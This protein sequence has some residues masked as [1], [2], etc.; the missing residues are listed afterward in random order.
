MFDDE[1]LDNLTDVIDGVLGSIVEDLRAL[2]RKNLV[3]PHGRR[4]FG[5]SGS[6]AINFT[7]TQHTEH[8]GDPYITYGST[9][10]RSPDCDTAF[11]FVLGAADG[12]R[13]VIVDNREGAVL[14]WRG[15]DDLHGTL[16]APETLDIL[17]KKKEGAIGIGAYLKKTTTGA[18][19]RYFSQPPTTFEFDAADMQAVHC[20]GGVSWASDGAPE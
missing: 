13:G 1:V 20:P 8:A 18:A 7:S 17:Q 16:W 6:A 10:Y 5:I 4:G 15:R 12:G 19:S 14:V 11:S 9:L 2:A 3:P